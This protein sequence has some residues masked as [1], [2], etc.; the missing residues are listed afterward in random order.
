MPTILVDLDDFPTG[1]LGDLLEEGLAA[2]A[3]DA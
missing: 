1:S 2:V 3:A